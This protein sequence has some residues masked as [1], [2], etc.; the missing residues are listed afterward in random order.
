M[1]KNVPNEVVALM[2]LVDTYKRYKEYITKDDRE[3]YYY[4]PSEWGKCLRS[5][6]YKH[7]LQKGYI[8]MDFN[9]FGS[10]ILRLFD[11]G[12]YMHQRWVDYF[13][14]MGN[15]L[16]GKWKCKNP[17][18]YLF[19]DKKLKIKDDKRIQEILNEGKTRV[20]GEGYQGVFRPKV[21]EC[22][23][24]DFEYIE[25]AVE[26]DELNMR[27]HSDI[28]LDCSDLEKNKFKDVLFTFN[29]DHL[30]KK[31]KM[32]GDMKT[33]N[34]NGWNYQIRKKGPHPYYIIQLIIYIHILD[35]EYGM[36]MYEKK[37]DSQMQWFKIE[38][39]EK[40]WKKIKWQAKTMIDMTKGSKKQLP[41]PKPERKTSFECK[42]CDFKQI[43]HKS[44]VWD[45]PNL[46]KKRIDFY[47]DTLEIK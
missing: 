44:K 30:P 45:D 20:Y 39:N 8:K 9:S 40:I 37:D 31:G 27:G 42:F 3:Y 4:H 13:D 21:C 46:D 17:Y 1:K 7:Y 36:L 34:I 47:G 35:C 25:T 19:E 12:H 16:M 15:I 18:C 32:V 10:R 41:P 11:G 33:I 28:I 2:G 22:G 43:C 5:Q 24:K 23:C 26:C 29:Y 38:R 14:D 6:Q